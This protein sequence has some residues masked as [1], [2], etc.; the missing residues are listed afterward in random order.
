MYEFLRGSVASIDVDGHLTL[1]VHN[2][3]YRLRVS[4]QTRH[5]LPLDGSTIMVHTRLLVRDDGWHLFGFADVAER[6]A[7][8]LL[9]SVNGIG[10]AVALSLCSA[11]S[12]GELR[13]LLA[14]KDAK[15]LQQVKGVGAK[16]AQ[17]MALELHDKVER[18]PV[19]VIVGTQS[20]GMEEAHQALVALGFNGKDAQKAL[21]SIE[22]QHDDPEIL[23]R[24]A[25]SRM[26]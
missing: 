5:L 7:F 10:P 26:R 17:R 8:D 14:N 16:G 11:Y 12:A 23:L 19:P 4:E 25:L 13:Q 21:E 24:L 20:A 2:V 6:A 15:A 18:I 3:G 22:E 1:E 9:C